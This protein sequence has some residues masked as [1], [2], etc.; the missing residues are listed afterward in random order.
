MTS[1]EYDFIKSKNFGKIL[2]TLR[3]AKDADLNKEQLKELINK[4]LEINKET[5]EAFQAYL[6]APLKSPKELHA[7]DDIEW[8][9]KSPE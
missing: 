6:K 9:E 2:G 3:Y 7:H 8:A 5:D 4:C 1:T